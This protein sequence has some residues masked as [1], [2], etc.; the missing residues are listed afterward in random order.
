MFKPDVSQT[1]LQ[2]KISRLFRAKR[3]EWQ[4]YK[5]FLQKNLF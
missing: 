3:F 5:I 2:A 1:V 4:F